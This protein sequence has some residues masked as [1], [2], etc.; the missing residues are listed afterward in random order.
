[1]KMLEHKCLLPQYV[2]L[3]L[4]SLVFISILSSCKSKKLAERRNLNEVV[5]TS[6]TTASDTFFDYTLSSIKTKQLQFR[7]LTM[8]CKVF[9]DDG[10]MQQDFTA[11]VRIKKDS[12]IWLSLT[13]IF[14]IEGARMIITQDSVFLLNKLT[15]EYLV[16]PVSYLSQI[17]PLSSG[18]DALQNLLIGQLVNIEP[19]EHR[20][21]EADSML[22][23]NFQNTNLRQTAT[24]HRQN[25]TTLDLLLADQ[26][27]KQDLKITFGDYRDLSGSP[28]SFLRFIEVNRGLQKMK[29][30]MEVQRYTIDEPLTFPLEVNDSY[31][32]I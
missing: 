13:G 3:F 21:Y 25:Y 27:I 15:R 23:L 31:K 8:R 10:K 30:N 20:I 4:I 14:G 17:I 19:A 28:F 5:S 18:Y 11:N 24:L 1:M 32:R 9:Y 29:I 7:S 16:R 26:L 6:K 2:V 22:I 12:I